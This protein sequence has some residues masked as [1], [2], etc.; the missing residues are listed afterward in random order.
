MKKTF[1]THMDDHAGAFLQAC[2]RISPLDVNITRVSYDKSIDSRT[3][4]IEVE[5]E[6][7]AVEEAAR[8][9]AGIGYLQDE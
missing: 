4:F 2:E 5:G 6:D 1:V 7:G 9:L 8:R 3:L